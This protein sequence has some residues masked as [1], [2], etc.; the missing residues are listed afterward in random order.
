MKRTRN[1]SLFTN[2]SK[3]GG[4]KLQDRKKMGQ[5]EPRLWDSKVQN[6]LT[7][8]V[9]RSEDRV[10]GGSTEKKNHTQKRPQ[11]IS[12]RDRVQ[13]MVLRLKNYLL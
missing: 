11:A 3:T 13:K 10:G 5:G 9:G 8:Y 1:T 6:S 12:D 4:K 7:A 2:K